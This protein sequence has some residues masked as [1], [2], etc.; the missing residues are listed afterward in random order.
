MDCSVVPDGVSFSPQRLEELDQL[1]R[2]CWAEVL[3]RRPNLADA[4][5]GSSVRNLIASRIM[6]GAATGIVD[7]HELRQKA[8][9]GIL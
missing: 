3:A 5:E 1:L 9:F 2:A 8:L 7:A 6:S 4:E